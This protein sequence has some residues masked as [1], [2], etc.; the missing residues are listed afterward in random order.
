M[1]IRKIGGG[2][3]LGEG[4][5]ASASAVVLAVSVD[6]LSTENCPYLGVA[7]PGAEPQPWRGSFVPSHFAADA[8][9]SV[10]SLYFCL[11][12]EL[13]MFMAKEK[14]GVNTVVFLNHEPWNFPLKLA[15][16]WRLLEGVAAMTLPD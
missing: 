11:L 9:W 4:S 15:M 14:C 7:A 1:A 8:L 2:I 16:V 3:V 6:A 10:I 5:P 12:L 13:W